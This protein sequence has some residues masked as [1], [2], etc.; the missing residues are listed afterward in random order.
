MKLLI[1]LTIVAASIT[2]PSMAHAD[3]VPTAGCPASK[4][5]LTVE[6][7]LARVDFSIYDAT[8]IATITDLIRALDVS[9]NHDGFLCSKQFKPNRGQGQLGG[10]DYVIT[11]MSDNQ[12]A[13]RL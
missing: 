1:S 4:D 5:L 2:M 11:Q 12:P 10:V 9:G 7:T 3:A 8:D 6:A 13:G